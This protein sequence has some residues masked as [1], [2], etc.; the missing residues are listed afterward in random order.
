MSCCL[1]RFAGLILGCFVLAEVAAGCDAHPAG[2]ASTGAGGH[3]QTTDDASVTDVATPTPDPSGG[4]GSAGTTTGS[5]GSDAAIVKSCSTTSAC[6]GGLICLGGTC[7]SDP[8]LAALAG[9]C[10][11]A[12]T[13]HATC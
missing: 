6:G 9:T 1:R 4:G 5:G 7:Q 11:G 13:C 2:V 12:N 10:T 3:P 8:C